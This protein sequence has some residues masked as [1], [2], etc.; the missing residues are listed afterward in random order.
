[1]TCLQSLSNKIELS[2]IA[3][4]NPMLKVVVQA[5]KV[6]EAQEVDMTILWYENLW[7]LL[8]KSDDIVDWIALMLSSI[9]GDAWYE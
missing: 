4:P 2:F 1:M 5:L 9:I 7:Y 6:L 3:C 8:K